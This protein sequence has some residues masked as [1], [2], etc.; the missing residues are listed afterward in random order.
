MN[1]LK[2]FKKEYNKECERY[3][4]YNVSFNIE[5]EMNYCYYSLCILLSTR[6]NLNLSIQFTLKNTVIIRTKPRF[7]A[8]TF[9]EIYFNNANYKSSIVILKYTKNK[10]YF[11]TSYENKSIQEIINLINVAF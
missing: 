2:N 7:N 11:S 5:K 6:K 1:N 4:N 8:Y 3:K 10:I 9:I